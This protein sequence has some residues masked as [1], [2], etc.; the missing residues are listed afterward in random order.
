[1]AGIFKKL[2]YSCDIRPFTLSIMTFIVAKALEALKKASETARKH[3]SESHDCSQSRQTI[4]PSLPLPLHVFADFNRRDTKA[5]IYMSLSMFY[6]EFVA[7]QSRLKS[8]MLLQRI[9]FYDRGEKLKF[10]Q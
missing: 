10:Y 3:F 8:K 2:F 6:F 9:N 1:M 4:P 5:N 7:V